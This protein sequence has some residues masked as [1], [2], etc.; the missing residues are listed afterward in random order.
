[1]PK[2]DNE[3]VSILRRGISRG[4]QKGGIQRG[5]FALLPAPSFGADLD[6]TVF[7]L[8][9]F[10]ALGN[11]QSQMRREN[12]IA[13]VRMLLHARVRRLSGKTHAP[14]GQWD[15]QVAEQF[16]RLRKG[17][18]IFGVPHAQPLQTNGTPTVSHDLVLP[19][20]IRAELV[21]L[22]QFG[23]EFSLNNVGL[24]FQF[25][26]PGKELCVGGSV[27]KGLGGQAFDVFFARSMSR[28]VSG[29]RGNG[30]LSTVCVLSFMYS[31][32]E[33]VACGNWS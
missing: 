22:A 29:R 25:L 23:L 33:V 26:G 15:S 21:G 3:H 20:R 12:K 16:V 14:D 32:V 28:G 24:A 9:A 27:P 19:N 18:A 13:S 2:V 11:L 17:L 30:A 10:A 1:M 7:I 4:V 5:Q 6:P 8:F 31:E